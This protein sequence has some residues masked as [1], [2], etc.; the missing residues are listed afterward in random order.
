MTKKSALSAWVASSAMLRRVARMRDP[1]RPTTSAIA[2]INAATVAD[3]RRGAVIRLSIASAPFHRPHRT[4][5]GRIARA[6]QDE[7]SGVRSSAAAIAAK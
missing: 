7:S 2:S 1:P 5:A 3:V 4:Q 6:S